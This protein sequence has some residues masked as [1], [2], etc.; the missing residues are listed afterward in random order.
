MTNPGNQSRVNA[1]PQFPPVWREAA[2]PFEALSLRRSAIWRG[3][4]VPGGQGRPVL[5]IPGYW[6][7][8]GSLGMLTTWL[9]AV[10]YRTRR[11][12]IGVNVACSEAAC[13]QLESL[14]EHLR[15]RRGQRVAI[16]GVE[17]RRCAR[18]GARRR[19]ARPGLGDR[20]ARSP[21][22]TPT[23]DIPIARRARVHGGCAGNGA[24]ARPFSG[25]RHRHVRAADSGSR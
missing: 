13:A 6:A 19:Q 18:E 12:D 2:F 8:D 9:R 15:F 25:L 21:D 14:L 10:G 7:G 3:E 17:P 1:L 5:L 23:S 20:D 22:G 16:V 24:P 11:A 4:G